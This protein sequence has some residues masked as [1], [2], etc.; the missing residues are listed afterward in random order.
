MK[1][2]SV[3][4]RAS[5]AFHTRPKIYKPD[6]V[7]R[8]GIFMRAAGCRCRWPQS[9]ISGVAVLLSTSVLAP[10]AGAHDKYKVDIVPQIPH[11]EFV[12]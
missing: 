11:S 12:T 5:F 6:D 8:G 3:L 10:V 9:L 2:E 1:C 4:E 7:L